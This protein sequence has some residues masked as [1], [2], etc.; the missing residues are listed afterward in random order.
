MKSPNLTKLAEIILTLTWSEMNEIVGSDGF[1]SRYSSTDPQR[2][3]EWA[4]KQTTEEPSQ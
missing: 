4:K 3:I 1:I 2:L